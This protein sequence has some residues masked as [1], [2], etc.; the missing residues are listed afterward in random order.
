[1]DKQKSTARRKNGERRETLSHELQQDVRNWIGFTQ[2]QE[3]LK[4]QQ[5]VTDTWLVLAKQV[6]EDDNLSIE[7]YWL[8]GTAS[9]QPAL[10]L[11]F[12][13][14]GQGGQLALTPGIYIQAEL[15]FYPSAVPLRAL[16]KRQINA[17][18]VAPGKIFSGWKE[19]AASET[20]ANALS[21][22]TSI[23]P[24]VIKQVTPAL[25]QQ[26]WWLADKNND[27]ISISESFKNIW[28]L[29][30]ISGGKFVTVAV[31]GKEKEYEPVGVWVNEIYKSL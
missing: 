14:R 22:F 20:T 10:I 1:L 23:K 18:S 26:R 15:V 25:Y 27:M 12:L 29:L 28:K 9:G 17:D 24:Y 7:K 2:N 30:A 13:I 21:P 5:G 31:I 11:Q 8:H 19:I 4:E 16:I 3:E 6:S